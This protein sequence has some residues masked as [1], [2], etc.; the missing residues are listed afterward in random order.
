MI[1]FYLFSLFTD[2]SYLRIRDKWKVLCQWFFMF[3]AEKL[4]FGSGTH[5]SRNWSPKFYKKSLL[6]VLL[7]PITTFIKSGLSCTNLLINNSYVEGIIMFIIIGEVHQKCPL[8]YPL[9]SKT[10][11]KLIKAKY[12]IFNMYKKSL[13]ADEITST[14]LGR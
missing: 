7:Q 5:Y 2:V 13:F 9:R 6:S 3:E 4:F 1:V 11:I 12:V 14:F 8:S 10:F